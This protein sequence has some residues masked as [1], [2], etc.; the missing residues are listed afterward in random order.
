MI[1]KFESF[2]FFKVHKIQIDSVLDIGAHKGKWTQEF[3]N[4]ILMLNH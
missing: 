4:I 2:E 1:H 3:K